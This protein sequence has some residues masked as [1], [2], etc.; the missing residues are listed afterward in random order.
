M[1][2][3][4]FKQ[5]IREMSSLISLIVLTLTISPI[6][7]YAQSPDSVEPLARTVEALFKAKI[8]SNLYIS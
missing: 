4:R 6:N 2:L 5:V 8:W 3:R 7:I 1:V